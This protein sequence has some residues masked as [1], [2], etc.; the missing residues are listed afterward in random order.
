MIKEFHLTKIWRQENA[1]DGLI[2]ARIRTGTQTDQDL[3]Y[4]NRNVREGAPFGCTVLSPYVNKVEELNHIALRGMN[5]ME[6]VNAA[7]KKGTYLKKEEKKLPVSSVLHLKVGCRVIIKRNHKAATYGGTIQ[8]YNGNQG[9]YQGIDKR[10]RLIIE[11]D[12]GETAIIKKHKW[13]SGTVTKTKIIEDENG[14]ERKIDVLKENTRNLFEQYPVKLGFAITITASQGMTLN[15][16]YL[17]LGR[18]LWDDAYGHLYVAM[19]R[20][21]SLDELYLSR[22]LMHSD[23][24]VSPDL[25]RTTAEQFKMPIE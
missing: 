4:V 12:N 3:E 19:S 23:N 20:V 22:K 8:V 13:H 2:L 15:R 10:Q 7:R 11:L 1:K 16:V 9:V 17:D 14:E 24:K 21:K 25:E 18:G 6:F 5:T